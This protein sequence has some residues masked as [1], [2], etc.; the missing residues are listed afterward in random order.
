MCQ[1]LG[2]PEQGGGARGSSAHPKIFV[3]A[4]FFRGALEVPFL[5]EVTQYV[6]EN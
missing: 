4:P 6:H 5:K 1:N 3:D 2:P